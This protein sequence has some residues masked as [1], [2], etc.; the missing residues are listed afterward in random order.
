[1]QLFEGYSADELS[2]IL[3]TSRW[4]FGVLIVLAAVA[5][6]FTQWLG[7]QIVERESEQRTRAVQRLATAELE[8]RNSDAKLKDADAT[9]AR[10]IAPRRLNES[11]IAKLRTSL[12]AGP[13]GEVIILFVVAEWDAKDYARQISSLL[14]EAGFDAKVSEHI[15]PRADH[16]GVF[17][18]ASPEGKL[19]PHGKSIQAEFVQAGVDMESHHAPT[20]TK[21]IGA[22]PGAAVLVVSNR[23]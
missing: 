11:Q 16:D 14:I 15:L 12:K 10:L 1:M 17:L 3:V 6:I 22:S 5:G 23:K 8:L 2:R 19:S 4:I 18:C 9:L 7:G 21:D 13:R 20:I